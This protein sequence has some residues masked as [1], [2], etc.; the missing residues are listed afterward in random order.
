[1]KPLYTAADLE[2]LEQA[3]TLPGFAPFLRG[4]RATMYAN[5]PWTSTLRPKRVSRPAKSALPENAR[6]SA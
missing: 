3:G 1:M 5:R 2:G 6:S 4:P